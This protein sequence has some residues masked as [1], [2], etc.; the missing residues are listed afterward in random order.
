M[1]AKNGNDYMT[2][3]IAL[4]MKLQPKYCMSKKDND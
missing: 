4:I 2:N 3:K 1:E